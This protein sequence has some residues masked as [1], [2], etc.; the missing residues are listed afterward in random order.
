[1]GLQKLKLRDVRGS[2]VWSF[3]KMFNV[4]PQRMPRSRLIGRVEHQLE[5][6]ARAAA[7]TYVIAHKR[8]TGRAGE[9]AHPDRLRMGRPLAT[10]CGHL[11]ILD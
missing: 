10:P 5:D 2:F 1:M 7:R 6:L 9:V 3:R 11:E 8:Y 4:E